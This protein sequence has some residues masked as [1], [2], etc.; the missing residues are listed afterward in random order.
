M[1]E[2]YGE[3][4][5]ELR[6]VS[7]ELQ[8]TNE[9]HCSA[10]EKLETSKEE[11]QSANEKLQTI[12]NELKLKV[13]SLGRVYGD[14]HNLI[15]SIDIGTLFLDRELRIKRFTPRVAE[16]FNVAESDEGRPITDFTHRLQYDA[17]ASDARSVL[18]HLTP[19]DKEITSEDGRLFFVRLRPY[20]DTEDQ[21]G[22]VVITFVDVTE[23]RKAEG[24]L[25]QSQ[26]RLESELT[27]TQQLHDISLELIHEQD[28]GP[29]YEKIV[30]AASTIMNPQYASL[31]MFCPERGRGGELH[32]LA[33]RGF[34]PRFASFLEWVR[35]DSATTSAAALRTGQ[36]VIVAD[37][38]RCDFMAGTESLEMY[39]QAGIHAA[40]TTPLIARSGHLL[41]ELSTHWREPHEAHE[42]DLRMLDLLARQAADIIERTQAEAN[43][44][45][46]EEHFRAMSDNIAQLVWTCEQLCEVTW[47]NRRWLDY[48][49]LTFEEMKGAGWKKIHHPDHVDRVVASITHSRDTGEIWEDTFPLRGKDGNYRWFLSRAVPIRDATGKIIQWFGTNTDIASEREAEERRILLTNELAH[50]GKNLL[51]VVQTLIH[52]SLSG[53]RSFSEARDILNGRI[54]ALSRSQSLLLNEDFVGARLTEIVHLEFEA[55]SEQLDASGPD[56]VLNPRATQS[57][58]LLVHELATNAT[59]YGA[60]SLPQGRVAIEWSIDGEGAQAKLKFSWQELGGPPVTHPKQ[61]GFGRTLIES[62]MAQDF[63]A[64]PMLEFAPEGLRYLIDAP[65]SG[66]AE[67]AL[68]DPPRMAIGDDLNSG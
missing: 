67:A 38:S 36:R 28:V 65:L 24:L 30:E 10:G 40:Q 64:Q 4:I 58:A 57:F 45:R 56:L 52:R 62:A 31:K 19:F 35:V 55:F 59:K 12:N 50:R 68:D 37:V 1:A 6:D 11:L 34:N 60:L 5:E 54:H 47:Y 33:H 25:R 49:G 17:L 43:L 22:G 7:E 29:L 41:G 51:T 63:G 26:Q 53:T 23:P 61:N 18:D 9:V 15:A 2:Q 16:L 27:A 3:T 48:A 32:L 13:E 8:S 14:I 20:R 42:N 66:I 44:R 21:I 39:L 46:S